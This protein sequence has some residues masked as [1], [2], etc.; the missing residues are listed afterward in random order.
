MNTEA[1]RFRRGSYSQ[2]GEDLIVQF[3]FDAI[4]IKRPSYI[5]IGAHHPFYLNNTAI[6]Y[7]LGSHGVNVEPDPA[8]FLSFERHRKRDINLNCGVSGVAQTRDF[9]VMS[10]PTTN[11][12]SKQEADRLVAESNLS[13]V[14]TIPVE[15]KP[16][17]TII[18]EYCNNVFPDFLNLDIEGLDEEVIASID[19]K[20]SIPTVICLETISY[21]ET[22]RGEKNEKVIS[23]LKERGYM[24]YA[25]TFIN[26][27]FVLR[28]KWLKD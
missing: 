9:Y 12:F 2:S 1:Y 28:N 8:L 15:L 24:V 16:V 27:I 14:K 11:T 6:F 13:I 5:D 21:S 7:E 19:F 23:L 22:G 10:V 17:P 3:I 26:T 20:S 25:D 4:G 18:A